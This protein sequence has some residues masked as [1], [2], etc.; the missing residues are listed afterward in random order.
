M[1]TGMQPHSRS[2]RERLSGRI[3]WFLD[4]M[5]RPRFAATVAASIAIVLFLNQAML[6][7]ATG[8]GIEDFLG[9]PDTSPQGPVFALLAVWNLSGVWLAAW[10]YLL[11]DTL[12]FVPAYAAFCCALA[13]RVADAVS[14]QDAGDTTRRERA[15]LFVLG[16]P[17]FALVLVDLA[18]NALGLGR[19]GPNG[20]PIA[21]IASGA[22]LLVLWK[23]GQSLALARELGRRGLGLALTLAAVTL[24]IGWHAGSAC[25]LERAAAAWEWLGPAGCAAHRGKQFL[26]AAVVLVLIVGASAWLFGVLIEATP[27]A[28]A[29]RDAR[30]RLRAAI[31][32]ILLR[33]RYVLLALMLLAALTVGLDQGRDVVYAMAAAPFGTGKPVWLVLGAIT[34][35]I[36]LAASTELLSFSCWLWT[37][38]VCQLRPQADGM[39]ARLDGARLPVED[40]FAR[41]WA[42]VLATVPLLVVIVLCRGVIE[43]S[44]AAKSAAVVGGLFEARGIGIALVALIFALLALF[45]GLYFLVRRVGPAE[46]RYYNCCDWAE[47]GSER[48]GLGKIPGGQPTERR[49]GLAGIAEPYWLPIVAITGM[50]VCRLFD[51]FPSHWLAWTQDYLPTM[52]LPVIMFALTLWLCFFGWLSML[53]VRQSIPWVGLL[54]V[55]IGVLGY[56]GFTD[57]HLVW[58]SIEAQPG[59]D[60]EAAVD[61]AGAFRMFGFTVMLAILVICIYAWTMRVVGVVSRMEQ[62]REFVLWC[63]RARAAW[64][65]LTG[66]IVAVGLVL[67][68]ADGAATSRP[69]AKVQRDTPDA[70]EHPAN[71]TQLVPAAP[72]TRISRQSLDG[73]LA[74]WLEQL[75][76]APESGAPCRPR[77]A[78]SEGGGYEV[79]F[80]ST[81][82]GGIRAGVWTAFTLQRFTD[83]DTDFQARTFSIS[84]VSGGAVGAAAFRA[85]S[86]GTKKAAECLEQFARTDLLAPLLSAW[87]FE[88]LLARVLPTSLLCDTPACG[89]L[90]RGAWFEQA[91]EAAAPGLRQG[92]LAGRG[93]PAQDGGKARHFPYLFLNSTWVE[94]GERAIASDIV[95]DWRRFRGAKDQLGI[96]D[97]DMPLGTAA[98]NSARFPFVNAIGALKAESGLCHSRSMPP[99]PDRAGS[100]RDG[101]CGHLADG[102][103]FDNS[104]AQTTLDVMNGLARCLEV[105]Q[106]DADADLYQKCIDLRNRDW[107]RAH[108]VPRVVMIRNSVQPAAA[109]EKV[110]FAETKPSARS[111]SIEPA[112]TCETLTS[113][114]YHPERPICRQRST[115]FVDFTG[116]AVT[117]LNVSGI[118]ASGQLAEARQAQAVRTLRVSMGGKAAESKAPPTTVVDLLPDGIRYP[119]GWH[120]SGAAVDGMKRQARECALTRNVGQGEDDFPAF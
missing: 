29:I 66:L 25:A 100:G 118:G 36:A 44:A 22:S 80:V 96:M 76:N 67:Y 14:N 15:A 48:A 78:A 103:Y 38:S 75:C 101:V 59:A 8:W 17:V 35:F 62:V 111:V 21:A 106:V 74:D 109:R 119:L 47:W 88:D 65:A 83:I 87:M 37:R 31:G 79:Y 93:Q 97:Q 43:D 108:L 9:W 68:W 39:P 114:G 92:L 81:E 41:D 24:A 5:R 7:V 12:F 50:L 27:Q 2:F 71:G 89:F 104:G 110:C 120:L 18:E 13:V 11:I 90:S 84:G 28:K 117:V 107:L 57:N 53:E 46:S 85:C 42:R 1:H 113:A 64:G 70:R 98:H 19:L 58:P 45:L 61:R 33:S 56:L 63:L 102:G 94:S 73:A 60:I 69:P 4:G 10:I 20:F 40:R 34:A 6:A 115:M 95:I 82:G 23:I 72:T 49:Y 55:L 116:P 32:D 91:M 112:G 52:T 16:V 77:I 86:M 54:I 3:D 30:A 99:E 26:L 105:R 51:V